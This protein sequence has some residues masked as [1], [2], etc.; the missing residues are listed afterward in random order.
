MKTENEKLKKA[1]G[2]Q[3]FLESLIIQVI[4]LGAGILNGDE[5]NM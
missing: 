1:L 3:N 4:I 5:N 2:I